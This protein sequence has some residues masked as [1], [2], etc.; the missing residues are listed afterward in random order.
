MKRRV[1][2]L[3]AIATAAVSGTA[4]A[5]PPLFGAIV[6]GLL[7]MGKRGAATR[8]LGSKAAPYAARNR[9]SRAEAINL[10]STGATAVSLLQ[11]VTSSAAYAAVASQPEDSPAVATAAY[12]VLLAN[13][14]R[15]AQLSMWNDPPIRHFRGPRNGKRY[16]IDSIQTIYNTGSRAVTRVGVWGKNPTEDWV[17]YPIDITWHKSPYGWLIEDMNSL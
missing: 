3:S 2:F 14:D 8:G 7:S 9:L 6:R 13:S 16:Q 11:G 15:D 4:N 5:A 10:L 17:Y 1:F 12:Y